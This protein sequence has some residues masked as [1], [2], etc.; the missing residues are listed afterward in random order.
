M[1]IISPFA[2]RKP[3]QFEFKARYYDVR[4]E[5]IRAIEEAARR[6]R[7]EHVETSARMAGTRMQLAFH[8]ARSK[9]GARARRAQSLRTLAIVGVLMLAVYAYLSL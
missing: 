7:G 9:S 3:R 4:K 1:G 2:T 5:R 6:E 8:S